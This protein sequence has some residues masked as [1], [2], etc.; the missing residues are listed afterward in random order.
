ML[1]A[2]C[3]YLYYWLRYR[4]NKES[5]PILIM[6]NHPKLTQ[7]MYLMYWVDPKDHIL[8]VSGQYLHFQ[9][10]YSAL[11]IKLVTCGRARERI[12]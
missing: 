6:P 8:K 11:L 2:S 9:L 4:L 3:Q 5:R 12:R 7:F 1:K 10:S